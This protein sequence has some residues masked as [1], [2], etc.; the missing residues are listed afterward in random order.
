[1]NHIDTT[2]PQLKAVE[3]IFEAYR[4]CDLNN[5]HSVLSKNFTYR[6]FPKIAE[7]PDQTKEEHIQLYGPMFA[8]V[9]KIEVGIQH[10]GTM[11]ASS[12]VEIY[13]Y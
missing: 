6:S 13:N 5:A 10:R 1:M 9:A 2:T 3:R 7:L 8:R 12:L 4:T 11:L